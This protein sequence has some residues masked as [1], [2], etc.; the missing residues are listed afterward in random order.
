[1]TAPA[2]RNGGCWRDTRSSRRFSDR[3]R[4]SPVK[5]ASQRLALA[6]P[7]A[8]VRTRCARARVRLPTPPRRVRRVRAA[9]SS[10]VVVA[11]PLLS[12]RIPPGEL[13]GF[14]HECH[15]PHQLAAD[16]HAESL[17]RGRRHLGVDAVRVRPPRRQPPMALARV[18]DEVLPHP[19]PLVD[20]PL[21][22]VVLPPSVCRRH[23]RARSPGLCPCS[24]SGKTRRTAADGTP[25]A[26]ITSG[27]TSG[28]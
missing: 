17:V 7:Q 28:A 6:T 23:P 24:T 20:V 25:N 11:A 9:A 22:A 8:R 26:T 12:A 10:L 1:M 4:A 2:K 27:T 16:A 14:V 19:Q 18:V 5:P 15:Q 13:A 21:P 3:V